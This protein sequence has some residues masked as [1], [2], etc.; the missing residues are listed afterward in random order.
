MAK[1]VKEKLSRADMEEVIKGG[2]S[3]MVDGQI[4]TSVKG[5]PDDV[6]LAETEEEIAAAEEALAAQEQEVAAKK[7]KAKKKAAAKKATT[8]ALKK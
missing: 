2:G 8:G 4:I 5:L 6:D 3:V 7:A 1:E